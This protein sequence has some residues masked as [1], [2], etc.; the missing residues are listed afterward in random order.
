[1]SQLTLLELESLYDELAEAIDAVGKDRE[2]V[3][4]AKLI[5]SIAQEFGDA[6]RISE[7]IRDCLNEPSPSAATNRLI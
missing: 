4:L 5:L 2:S 6:K 7:L 3:F 1:M